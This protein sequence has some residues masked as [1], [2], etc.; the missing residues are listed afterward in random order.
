MGVIEHDCN[1]SSSALHAKI[2]RLFL[3]MLRDMQLTDPKLFFIFL[4]LEINSLK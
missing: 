4:L 1:V 2:E 3:I